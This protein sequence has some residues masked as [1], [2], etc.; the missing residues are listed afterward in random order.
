MYWDDFVDEVLAILDTWLSRASTLTISLEFVETGMFPPHLVPTIVDVLLANTHRWKELKLDVSDL[1]LYNFLRLFSAE[2][3]FLETLEAR[4]SATHWRPLTESP[5]D[6]QGDAEARVPR[7]TSLTWNARLVDMMIFSDSWS[8]L[9]ELS[10]LHEPL[11]YHLQISHQFRVLAW[12]HNLATL[13]LGLTNIPWMPHEY[14]QTIVLPCLTTLRLR[15][16]DPQASIWDPCSTLV[17]P[18]LKTPEIDSAG[19][20]IWSVD[21][22]HRDQ[23]PNLL[24]RS[25]CTLEVLSV[26]HVHFM[27]SEIID[28]L[29][30]TPSLRAFT[31][32]ACYEWTWMDGLLEYLA[33]KSEY[34]GEP[35]LPELESIQ[36]GF[37]VNAEMPRADQL[38]DLLDYR[39]GLLK[40]EGKREG[41]IRQ[42]RPLL[43]VGLEVDLF[44]HRLPWYDP[45]VQEAQRIKALLNDFAARGHITA[46]VSIERAYQTKYP[47]IDDRGKESYVSPNLHP[48]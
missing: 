43:H 31:F 44:D 29:R 1:A 22:W 15:R 36:F 45:N 5:Q 34:R 8:Q 18:S 17:T 40:S 4:S 26:R 38:K 20:L 11:F 3:P 25:D 30:C 12:T 33:G 32:F 42:A 35:P 27:E 6:F 16:M 14:L 2:L 37:V 46:E 41:R 23:V 9:T 13:N 19:S 24:R 48:G 47:H 10:I 39:L 7:L 21:D 28:I